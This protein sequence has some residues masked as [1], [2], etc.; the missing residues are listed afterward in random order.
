MSRLQC[1]HGSSHGPQGNECGLGVLGL[2]HLPEV[3][4]DTVMD[5]QPKGLVT[6]NAGQELGELA[7][8]IH[9]AIGRNLVDLQKVELILRWIVGHSRNS[10]PASALEGRRSERLKKFRKA[11]LGDLVQSFGA[12]V[13]TSADAESDIPELGAEDEA[14]FAFRFQLRMEA[15]KVRD[16][17]RSLE[18]LVQ[19]RNKLVHGLLERWQQDSME[20]GRELL[21][22][23]EEQHRGIVAETEALRQHATSLNEAAQELAEFLRSAAGKR[24]VREALQLPDKL[25]SEP[26]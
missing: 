12:D 22:K 20:S 18:R 1:G 9:R 8:S 13:L 4:G 21:Q 24:L 17:K 5:E 15:G 11:G 10:G 7:D 26:S 2:F 3:S 6:A 16:T 23:L 19:E 25:D 14:H